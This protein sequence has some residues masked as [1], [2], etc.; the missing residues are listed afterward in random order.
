[1]HEPAT[2]K[3]AETTR[4][5]TA[6]AAGPVIVVP[7]TAIVR[8]LPDNVATTRA[9]TPLREL[10]KAKPSAVVTPS[11]ETHPAITPDIGVSLAGQAIDVSMAVPFAVTLGPPYSMD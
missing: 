2:V 5:S 8:I 4:V 6:G 9:G 1:M 3:F 10:A 11:S 7:F